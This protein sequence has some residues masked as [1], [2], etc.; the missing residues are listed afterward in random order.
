[1]LYLWPSKPGLAIQVIVNTAARGFFLKGLVQWKITGVN[2]EIVF[3][4][5]P[6]I[7]VVAPEI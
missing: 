6:L 3:I 1:M 5:I 7:Y 2:S 4:L